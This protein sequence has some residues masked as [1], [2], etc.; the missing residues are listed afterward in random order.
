PS[1]AFR[2]KRLRFGE[3]VSRPTRKKTQEEKTRPMT[4]LCRSQQTLMFFAAHDERPHRWPFPAAL[5]SPAEDA[6]IPSARWGFYRAH[7]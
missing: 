7:P 1:A 4:F 6:L 2:P 5:P 3:A